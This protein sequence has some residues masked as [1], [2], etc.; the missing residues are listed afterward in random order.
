M[1]QRLKV[2]CLAGA[3]LPLVVG[4]QEMTLQRAA[5]ILGADD[6]V[7]IEYVGD[8]KWHSIGEATVPGREWPRHDVTALVTTIDFTTP[9][10]RVAMTRV[11]TRTGRP[12][13][14]LRQQVDERLSGG[15]AW[16][17][18]VAPGAGRDAPTQVQPQPVAC[19][20]RT[21]DIWATPQG[22]IKAAIDRRATVVPA[23]GGA[24]VS[25]V[26]GSRRFNGRINSRGE[27][28]TVRAALADPVLGD[29]ELSYRYSEYRDFAGLKFPSRIVRTQGGYPVWDYSI[30]AAR[31]VVPT[32]LPV[33]EAVKTADSASVRLDILQLAEGVYVL[34]GADHNSVVVEQSDRVLV[35]EAPVGEAR[36]LAVIRKVKALIPRKPI[37]LVIN[38]HSHF[39]QSAGLRAFVA[40]GATVVTAALN[41]PF[42]ARVWRNAWTLRPDLMANRAIKPKFRTFVG[43]HTIPDAVRPVTVYPVVGSGHADGMAMV[44]LPRERFLIEADLFMMPPEGARPLGSPNPYHVNLFDNIAQRQLDVRLL[45]PLQG[46]VGHM[47]DLRAAVGSVV[48]KV[49]PNACQQE[50]FYC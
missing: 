49:L 40:E 38:T 10:Q 34:Q 44:Y 8:G 5:R 31:R 27:V 30:S 48:P 18:V 42:Y 43:P 1:R 6:L 32:P 33:P 4:A 35:I 15:W 9:S 28:E 36:S 3:L 45:V 21:S 19:D 50:A 13:P 14:P 39:A 29:T 46:R 2:L 7:G 26:I 23:S 41:R 20:G 17:M 37:R 11:E 16:D 25:F 12:R 22:F 47:S 24:D